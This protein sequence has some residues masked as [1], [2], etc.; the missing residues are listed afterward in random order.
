MPHLTSRYMLDESV[1]HS[2]TST[3]FLSKHCVR[4]Y[5]LDCI[6]QLLHSRTDKPLEFISRYFKEVRDGTNVVNRG[7]AYV[8]GTPRNRF[9][10]AS[11][12][13]HSYG[14][15]T[16]LSNNTTE[17]STLSADEFFQ[18]ILLLCSDFPESLAQIVYRILFFGDDSLSQLRKKSDDSTGA[19]DSAVIVSSEGVEGA[20]SSSS[21]SSNPSGSRPTFTQLKK[22]FRI[23]FFFREFFNEILNLVFE[24]DTNGSFVTV[25]YLLKH[26]KQCCSANLQAHLNSQYDGTDKQELELKHM[27]PCYPSFDYFLRI[28][29]SID[30]ST[31]LSFNQ[32]CKL[33]FDDM[34]DPYR[35]IVRCMDLRCTPF[36]PRVAWETHE[37]MK[38]Q[39]AKV[40]YFTE[41]ASVSNTSARA[42]SNLQIVSASNNDN[43]SESTGRSRSSSISSRSD[44]DSVSE[45]RTKRKKRSR[46]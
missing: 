44:T 7:F 38:K 8:N 34:T 26:L 33:I 32:F 40:L 13:E 45:K 41:N 12:L 36:T 9:A 17:T 16:T 21:S 10:F 18:L 5:M 4:F 20:S 37:A 43:D 24:H 19:G 35:D 15:T 46:D 1:R 30:K 22:A 3:Q 11:L 28:L 31:K 29:N 23:Y 39:I 27:T 2:L 14:N 6:E 25:E 42:E